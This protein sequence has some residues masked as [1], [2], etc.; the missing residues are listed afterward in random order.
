[1]IVDLL[2]AVCFD[3]NASSRM[4][5]IVT[6]VFL[7]LLPLAMIGGGL[8]YLRRRAIQIAAEESALPS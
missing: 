4:A 6:T 3:P 5:F 2:C 1:M 8:L 7:S